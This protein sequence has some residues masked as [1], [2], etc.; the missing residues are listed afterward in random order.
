MKDDRLRVP[1]DTAYLT[2]LGMATYCFA[3]MEWNA[4]YCGERL[5]PGYVNTVATKTAGR[6]AKDIVG[7]A[8]LI[9]NHTGP[10][11]N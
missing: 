7:F 4:V 5:S 2:T 8:Q 10:R 11:R 3:S 9:T 1:V 6:I